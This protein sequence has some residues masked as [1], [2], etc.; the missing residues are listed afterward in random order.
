MSSEN[1]TVVQS[2]ATS[3]YGMMQVIK[4]DGSAIVIDRF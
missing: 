2:S 1:N 3:S 4:N